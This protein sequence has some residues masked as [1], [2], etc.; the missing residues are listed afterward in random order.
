MGLIFHQG[1]H[2]IAFL[3]SDYALQCSTD[4]NS[5]KELSRPK[6]LFSIIPN[7][8]RSVM[9]HFYIFLHVQRS[10]HCIAFSLVVFIQ[11]RCVYKSPSVGSGR[12]S[13]RSVVPDGEQINKTRIT[14]SGP[15]AHCLIL[16]SCFRLKKRPEN[17]INIKIYVYYLRLTKLAVS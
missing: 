17:E 4:L 9:N 1:R 16:D 2:L 3:L 11:T 7:E 15:C 14:T 10:T 13:T 5:L 6:V 12:K 8:T